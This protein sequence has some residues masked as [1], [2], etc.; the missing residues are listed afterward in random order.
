[1][2]AVAFRVQKLN[3]FSACSYQIGDRAY[4]HLKP[5]NQIV[6]C[7]HAVRSDKPAVLHTLLNQKGLLPGNCRRECDKMDAE[8]DLSECAT[9]ASTNSNSAVASGT[10]VDTSK[11]ILFVKIYYR[12]HRCYCLRIYGLPV[13]Q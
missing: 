2:Y 4:Y 13:T 8:K 10:V 11:V 6:K 7:H 1:M 5:E 3:C 12:Y 9:T